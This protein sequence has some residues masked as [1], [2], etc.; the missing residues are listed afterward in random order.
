MFTDDGAMFSFTNNIG[1]CGS[2]CLHAAE[3]IQSWANKS[4]ASTRQ[5]PTRQFRF[6]SHT[7]DAQWH[8]QGITIGYRL[9]RANHIGSDDHLDNN[10]WAFCDQ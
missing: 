3:N 7:P 6:Y 8:S 2:H 5:C 10:G 1:K 9:N 4:H